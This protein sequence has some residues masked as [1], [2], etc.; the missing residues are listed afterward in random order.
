MEASG[1]QPL[2]LI[3]YFLPL[4]TNEDLD[5]TGSKRGGESDNHDT[6]RSFLHDTLALPHEGLRTGGEGGG[7]RREIGVQFS[8]SSL[9]CCDTLTQINIQF[10][11]HYLPPI[12]ATQTELLV[13]ESVTPQL[14]LSMLVWLFWIKPL[15]RAPS[16]SIFSLPSLSVRYKRTVIR[17]KLAAGFY[18]EKDLNMIPVCPTAE[19]KVSCIQLYMLRSLTEIVIELLHAIS[20]RIKQ[21]KKYS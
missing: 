21:C 10:S 6:K 14:R 4:G 1:S 17:Q 18:N 13:Q 8:G 9:P 12:T 7:T 11:P 15:H 2:L 19:E 5:W 3:L 20:V 16:F